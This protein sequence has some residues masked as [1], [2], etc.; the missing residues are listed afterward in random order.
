VTEPVRQPVWLRDDLALVLHERLVADFGGL[1]GVRDQGLLESAMARPRQLAAYGAADTVELAA[2]YAVGMVRNHPFID[3][4]KRVGFMLA[5]VF[6]VRNGY[7]F[8]ASEAAATRAVLDLASG[9]LSEQAF[10]RW[11]ADHS[12]PVA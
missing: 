7:R 1:V 5:Y 2:A 10:A 11:L 8:T 3:G 12:E 6:L 9:D 4:N